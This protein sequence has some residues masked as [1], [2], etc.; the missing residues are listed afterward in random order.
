MLTGLLFCFLYFLP[1]LCNG[2]TSVNLIHEGNEEDGI[3]VHCCDIDRD[4]TR[5]NYVNDKRVILSNMI[6]I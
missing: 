5:G 6:L 4:Y 3:L 2:I 1:L